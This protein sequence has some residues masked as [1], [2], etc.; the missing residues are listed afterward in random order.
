LQEKIN[1]DFIRKGGEEIKY[2]RDL[3][4][5]FD[6]KNTE[7]YLHVS[8]RDLVNIVSSLDDLWKKGKIDW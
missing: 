4:E 5:H 6:I 1:C 2:I 7:R 3:P 8:K